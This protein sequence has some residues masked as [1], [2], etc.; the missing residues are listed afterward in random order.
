MLDTNTIGKLTELEVLHYIIKLGYSASLPF[1]EKDR[2]D[3][4]WDINGKLIRIQVKTARINAHE[5]NPDNFSIIFNCRSSYTKRNK[6]MHHKYNKNEVDY[7]ATMWEN[8]L[9]LVPVEECSDR[10][11]L[12]FSTSQENQPNISWA[13]DYEVEK[14]LKRI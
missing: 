12:R 8:Q 5:K 7:F 4:I 1:G 6:T 3:Q 10:K 2:Y 9:Y 14:V 13:K 11:I